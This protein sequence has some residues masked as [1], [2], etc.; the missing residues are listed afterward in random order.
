MKASAPAF[1]FAALLGL[2]ACS[3]SNPLEVDA[4]SSAG[5]GSTGSTSSSGAPLSCSEL[6]QVYATALAAAQECNPANPPGECGK[7]A[8]DALSCGCATPVNDTTTLDTIRRQ[9]EA[10]DCAH[11]PTYHHVCL[12]GCVYLDT[13]KPC[14]VSMGA[15]WCAP[16]APSSTAPTDPWAACDELDAA[17][18]QAVNEA[19]S[20]DPAGGATQCL[21]MVPASLSCPECKVVIND[22]TAVDAAAAR[23]SAQCANRPNIACP[24]GCPIVNA[25]NACVVENGLGRCE[26][27]IP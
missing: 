7:T 18:G 12:A 8:P 22:A 1:L 25:P 21:V 26:G 19:R 20:C 15:G 3:G 16:R 23:W 17:Y 9:F 4:G 2:T 27:R 6:D 13:A 5:A 24:T 11:D 14:I 10:K